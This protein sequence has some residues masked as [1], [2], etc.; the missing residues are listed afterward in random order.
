MLRKYIYHFIQASALLAAVV[1]VSFLSLNLQTLMSEESPSLSQIALIIVRIVLILFFLTVSAGVFN[2]IFA[3][4]LNDDSSQFVSLSS[5]L[6]TKKETLY[7]IFIHWGGLFLI[8]SMFSFNWISYDM[9]LIFTQ[10]IGMTDLYIFLLVAFLLLFQKQILRLEVLILLAASILI[11]LYSKSQG[12]GIIATVTGYKNYFTVIWLFIFFKYFRFKNE[13]IK[14]YVN[15]I[16]IIILIQLPVQI[17]QFIILRDA[18][19]A[20]GT[21]G[22]HQTGVLGIFMTGAVLYILTL[23]KFTKQNLLLIFYLSLTPLIGSTKIF[24]LINFFLVPFILFRRVKMKPSYKIALIILL[25][26]IFVGILQLNR[27]WYEDYRT[28]GLNPFYYFSS[29]YLGSFVAVNP[30]TLNRGGA[31]IWTFS[32]LKDENKLFMGRGVGWRRS[33][34]RSQLERFTRL[35]I[36][37]DIPMTFILSGILGVLVFLYLAYS[38]FKVRIR[39]KIASPELKFF[40]LCLVLL[41]VVGGFYTQGWISKTTG[42]CFAMLIG[43][44]SNKFNKKFFI[45]KYFMSEKK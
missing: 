43:I 30:S 27:V 17:F 26:I 20:S 4:I 39:V 3:K 15:L 23:K 12:Y 18:E 29:K 24:F 34:P 38:L 45:E 7:K 10:I 42:Y 35:T 40:I 2:E 22:F 33:L 19:S 28:E 1:T 16:T 36:N 8:I 44:L 37:Y 41:Y 13:T 9:G 31:V 25:S 11:L 14:H 32:R 21:F 5:F 6:T